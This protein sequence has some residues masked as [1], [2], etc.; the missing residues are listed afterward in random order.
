MLMTDDQSIFMFKLNSLSISKLC[1]TIFYLIIN[2]KQYHVPTY[3][4]VTLFFGPYWHIYLFLN[5]QQK[6]NMIISF[7]SERLATRQRVTAMMKM[8]LIRVML[9]L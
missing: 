5:P 2:Y 1:T 6:N 8:T 3:F 9:V 7:S 4:V